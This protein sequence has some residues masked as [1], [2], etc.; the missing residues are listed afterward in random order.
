MIEQSQYSHTP[1][2]LLPNALEC[3]PAL[4]SRRPRTHLKAE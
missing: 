2:F 3:T 1:R 4:P